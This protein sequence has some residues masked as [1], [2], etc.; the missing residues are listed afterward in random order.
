[1]LRRFVSSSHRFVNPSAVKCTYST[2]RPPVTQLT[3]DER[4]L[5]ESVRKFAEEQVII[6]QK[7]HNST[8]LPYLT[9]F[10]IKR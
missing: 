1:M 3:E 8:F 2:A 7:Q 5:K 10:S 4:I 9:I 6:I